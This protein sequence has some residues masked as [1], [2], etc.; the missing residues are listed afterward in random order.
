VAKIPGGI[1]DEIKK[2]VDKAKSDGLWFYCIATKKWYTP[3]EFEALAKVLIV[4]WGESPAILINHP[5]CN[6]KSGIT[7]RVALIKRA[8]CELQ[9]FTDRVMKYYNF[10]RKD[11]QQ[12]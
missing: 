5:M 9:E 1:Y 7:Q 6:P 3:E 10:T 12:D 11:I 4:Q 8:S 2:A